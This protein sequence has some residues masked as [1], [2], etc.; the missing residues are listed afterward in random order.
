MI[1]IAASRT[2]G[3]FGLIEYYS[4]QAFERDLP[5]ATTERPVVIQ[6]RQATRVS[7]G[8]CMSRV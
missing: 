8:R 2:S 1:S 5:A 4:Q 7:P 6:K 3:L